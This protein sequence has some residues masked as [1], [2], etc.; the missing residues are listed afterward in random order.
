[1]RAGTESCTLKEHVRYSFTECDR[2]R[3]TTNVFFFYDPEDSCDM[4]QGKSE[5]LPAFMQDV[6]CD[7]LCPKD[8]QY[9]KVA[10]KEKPPRVAVPMGH[11]ILRKEPEIACQ[12]CGPNSIAIRGGFVYDPKMEDA[13]DFPGGEENVDLANFKTSCFTI[14]MEDATASI[15]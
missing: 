14:D 7:H 15:E 3:N 10:I 6:P 2:Q 9:A 8:G 4:R 13:A 12:E 1:V 5:A 11:N